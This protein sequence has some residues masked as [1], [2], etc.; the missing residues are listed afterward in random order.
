MQNMLD[1]KKS[2][3]CHSKQYNVNRWWQKHW[4]KCHLRTMLVFVHVTSTVKVVTLASFYFCFLWLH[5]LIVKI[6]MP[7]MLIF[8]LP[9]YEVLNICENWKP[10]IGMKICFHE[11]WNLSFMILYNTMIQIRLTFHKPIALIECVD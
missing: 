2:T 5:D 8:N 7:E 1:C 4:S 3:N 11:N 10:W 6:G 9:Q